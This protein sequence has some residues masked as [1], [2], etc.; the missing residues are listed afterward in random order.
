M[1][2]AAAAVA[3]VLMVAVAA[4]EQVVVAA[5]AVGFIVTVEAAVAAVMVVV[6]A[7]VATSLVVVV[8]PPY[9]VAGEDMVGVGDPLATWGEW[10]SCG[11]SPLPPPVSGAVTA[12]GTGGTVARTNDTCAS[13]R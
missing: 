6:G 3:V 1:E 4:V 8:V 13:G 2:T 7:P 10:R 12:L 5:E 11:K 9:E